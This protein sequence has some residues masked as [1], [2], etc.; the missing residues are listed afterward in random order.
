LQFKIKTQPGLNIRSYQPGDEHSL[1]ELWDSAHAELGGF[2]PKTPEYWK[3]C[4]V[5]RPGVE[6]EDIMI[7][8]HDER[9]VA[10]A[11]LAQKKKDDDSYTGYVLEF[12]IK[13]SLS[14]RQRELFANR[15]VIQIE[16]RS[17]YRGDEL[18]NLT[19]PSKDTVV[20]NVLEKFGYRAE[21]L[22]VFQLVIVDLVVLLKQI[23]DQRKKCFPSGQSPS[24]RVALQPGY[25]RYCP[26]ESVRIE[27][28]PEPVV[29]ESTSRADYTVSTDLST[30][31]DIIFRRS[32]FNDA[33]M[34]NSIKIYPEDGSEAV[35][36]LFQLVTLNS[37][38]YLPTVDGR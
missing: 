14:A 34:S 12:A 2:V 31:T 28:S 30:L 15:L 19:V 25:Y 16:N 24:F 26:Y 32:S 20:V 27:L 11:V 4:I 7:L 35:R 13:P 23:L 9:I 37:E 1:V 38:W 10:Y 8:E 6:P 36:S 22:D 17:R 18:L 21:A 33:L 5:D 29:E 3:W